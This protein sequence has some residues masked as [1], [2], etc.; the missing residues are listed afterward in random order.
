MVSRITHAL[1]R[2]RRQLVWQHLRLFGFSLL[3]LFFLLTLRFDTSLL[4]FPIPDLAPPTPLRIL[5]VGLAVALLVALNMTGYFAPG[6][7]YLEDHE[8]LAGVP[9]ARLREQARE[10]A[11]RLGLRPPRFRVAAL[12]SVPY[13]AILDRPG[14][15]DDLLLVPTHPEILNHPQDLQAVLAHEVGHLWAHT[16]LQNTLRV[17]YRAPLRALELAGYVLIYAAYL[18]QVGPLLSLFPALLYGLL[19]HRLTRL[20][21][22][23]T[24]GRWNTEL[25]YTNE[26]LADTVALKLLGLEAVANMLVRVH[27][28][29]LVQVILTDLARYLETLAP[30]I[31]LDPKAVASEAG[32]LL[33]QALRQHPYSVEQA[34]RRL[35]LGFLEVFGET[36]G[37][38]PR[39]LQDLPAKEILARILERVPRRQRLSLAFQTPATLLV[40]NEPGPE[41]YD[42]YPPYGQLDPGELRRLVRQAREAGRISIADLPSD[43]HPSILARLRHLLAVAG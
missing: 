8:T 17:V 14:S 20:L 2:L 41:R 42:L 36:L 37:L 1:Q 23:A 18:A 13:L 31:G 43:T 27:F 34:G 10:L 28:R 22:R 21:V 3:G 26:F 15:R 35:L 11:R 9:V 40:L 38:D 25:S 24:Y 30:Y 4:L 32:A 16:G 7:H 33:Q 39:A 6:V 5:G 29:I 12:E 19:W